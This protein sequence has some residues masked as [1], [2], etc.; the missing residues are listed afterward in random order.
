MNKFAQAINYMASAIDMIS[1]IMSGSSRQITDFNYNRADQGR[2]S[3]SH[4][5]GGRGR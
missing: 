2:G 3:N 1:K 5:R 4:G